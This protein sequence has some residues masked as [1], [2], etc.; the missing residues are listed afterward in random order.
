MKLI[1]CYI[2]NFGLLHAQS[3]SFSKGLNCCISENGTGKTTLTAFIEAMLYGIGDTRRQALDENPRKKYMPWQGGKFGGSLTLEVGKKKYVIERFFGQRPADDT[4][5]L[6]DAD[7]ARVS[8][9]YGDDIGEKLFGIDRDGF[10]RTAFLSEKNLQGKNDNKSIAAKLSDLVGVD[11]DVG[12]FDEAIKLLEERRKFYFKKGNTG[13]IANVKERISE[14]QRKIDSLEML[15]AETHRKESAL[16]EL[17]TE[18]SRL[19]D[20][21]KDQRG[22]RTLLSRER[23]RNAHEERY[24]AMLAAVRQERDKLAR[25]EEFFARHLPTA[26]EIDRIRDSHTTAERLR[27]EALAEGGNEEYAELSTFFKNG[28]DFAE[29]ADAERSAELAQERAAQISAFSTDSDEYSVK[30]R[31]IFKDK[32]PDRESIAAAESSGKKTLGPVKIAALVLG[33]ALSVG[34][35]AVGSAYGYIAAAIGTVVAVAA[36]ILTFKPKKSKELLSFL[37]EYGVDDAIDPKAGLEQIK[38]NLVHYEGLMEERENRSQVLEEEHSM[39]SLKVYSFLEKFPAVLA[40]TPLDCVRSIK[41]KY[42]RYYALTQ[43]GEAEASGKLEKLRRSDALGKEVSEFLAQFPT[44]TAAPFSEIRDRLN[45][46]NHLR[47][48]VARL[49]DE[50]D[51]YAVKYGVTGKLSQS[52]DISEESI[53]ATI[54]ELGEKIRELTARAAL[55]EQE[56]DT[57]RRE[58]ERKDEYVMAKDELEELLLAHTDSLDVIKKTALYLRMACDNITSKYLGKTKASFEEYSRLIAGIDGEYTLNTSFELMRTEHGES[59]GIESYS[60]GTKDLYALGL[61]LALIDALY[62]NEAPFIILDDP[63]ISLDDVRL[64]RAKA[65]LKSIGKSRQILYFTCAKSRAIE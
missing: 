44:V 17:Y 59:H 37:Q 50:C 39:H 35:I 15:E 34:G 3:Y 51:V 23:E 2:E 65:T 16:R 32:A 12:G 13:E 33:I 8:E 53:D 26:S 40:D 54:T 9:D 55:L 5:R 22:K 25:V 43:A 29:I 57:A 4:F 41:H 24:S 58:I 30:M 62:E 1:S 10:L 60:R 46:Y 11:G 14:C 45:E 19:E 38:T 49:E 48:G 7:S 61:R 31:K 28:T 42:T 20:L 18:R 27:S 63:F 52:R 36:A 47:A 64:E 6:I 21:E 56:I